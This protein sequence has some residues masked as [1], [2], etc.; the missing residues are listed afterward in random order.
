M[1][2][3]QINA[4]YFDIL[5][6]TRQN[7]VDITEQFTE[8]GNLLINIFQR[9]KVDRKHKMKDNK[10]CWLEHITISQNNTIVGYFAT[11]K[12]DY[13]PPVVKISNLTEREN[14][15]DIDEGDRHLTYFAIKIED[16]AH[17]HVRLVLH[18]S[19]HFTSRTFIN[20]INDMH[21]KYMMPGQDEVRPRF[22]LSPQMTNNFYT[23]LQKIVRASK[24]ELYFDKDVVAEK[25]TF[26]SGVSTSVKQTVKMD[27]SAHDRTS[28][29]NLAISA[30]NNMLGDGNDGIRDVFVR[31]KD[32]NNNDAVINVSGLCRM[33]SAKIETIPA[34]GEFDPQAALNFI[35]RCIED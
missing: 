32:V 29:E 22:D 10:F 1:A 2:T 6:I 34:T 28:L 12:A 15:R 18:K 13:R 14:P 24:M 9:D 16:N 5:K 11:A 17:P 4:N 7:G 30:V 3:K 33:S 20:Y 35:G 26:F 19:K 21:K 27:V 31:G 23:E 25:F 8:V